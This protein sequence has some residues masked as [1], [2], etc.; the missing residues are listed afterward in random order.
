[1][2]SA[3]AW[4]CLISEEERTEPPREQQRKWL[5]PSFSQH[6]LK[7]A[8]EGLMQQLGKLKLPTKHEDATEETVD[9]EESRRTNRFCDI[10]QNLTLF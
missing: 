5:K 9:R 7:A 8:T 10:S 1:M 2:P 3:K 4:I 6:P